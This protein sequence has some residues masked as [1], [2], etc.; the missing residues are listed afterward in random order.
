MIQADRF[1]HL[2]VMSREVPVTDHEMQL[3]EWLHEEIRNDYEHFVPKVYVAPA[4]A[5]LE[6]TTLSVRLSR[7]LLIDSR[8][9]FASDDYERLTIT[10]DSIIEKL[11]TMKAGGGLTCGSI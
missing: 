10:I 1:M 4:D 2:Y 11:S 6:T 5:L 9:V 8:P 7:E 3:L